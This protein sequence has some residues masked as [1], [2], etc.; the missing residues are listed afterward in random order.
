M[1]DRLIS[2]RPSFVLIDI[3]IEQW[4][5]IIVVEVVLKLMIDKAGVQPFIRYLIRLG[6]FKLYSHSSVV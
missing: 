5:H 6:S 2:H 4:V 1:K 3:N